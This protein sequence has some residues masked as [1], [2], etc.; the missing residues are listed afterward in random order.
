MNR[1]D[2]QETVVGFI[3]FQDVE[4][5]ADMQ[6]LKDKE[7][8]PILFDDYA[9]AQQQR[10]FLDVVAPV[11]QRR[12]EELCPPKVRRKKRRKCKLRKVQ[13]PFQLPSFFTI[14]LEARPTDEKTKEKRTKRKRGYVYLI[15]ATGLDGVYK[16]GQ[17]D[18]PLRRVKELQPFCPV[19]LE[20]EYVI[21]NKRGINIESRLHKH[22]KRHQIHH[23]WFRLSKRDIDWVYRNYDL[24][25]YSGEVKGQI[26]GHTQHAELSQIPPASKTA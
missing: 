11:T 21:P 1:M 18:D 20:I 8:I 16:V 7:G 17:S 13:Y 5:N 22:F 23:E 10:C 26:E 2:G 15:K 4:G 3:L 14:N 9:V 24:K 19:P 12:F 6:V 25:P